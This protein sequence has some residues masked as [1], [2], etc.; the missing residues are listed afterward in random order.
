MLINPETLKENFICG[1]M[2]GDYLQHN[3]VPLLSIVESDN[4]VKYYFRKTKMLKKAIQE[5]PWPIKLLNWKYIKNF[6]F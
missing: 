2:L 1:K 4:G 3:G 5:A 6:S